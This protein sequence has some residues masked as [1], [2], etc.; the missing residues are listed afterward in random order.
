MYASY[1]KAM[2]DYEEKYQVDVEQFTM[3]KLAELDR[4]RTRYEALREKITREQL[5]CECE[6]TWNES[7]SSYDYFSCLRC[8]LKN[9]MGVLE[10]SVR[11]YE[12][13]LPDD[14]VARRCV[15]FH[16][17]L[18]EVLRHYRDICAFMVDVCLSEA[19]ANSW[20]QMNSEPHRWS[21]ETPF[22]FL[23]ALGSTT[24]SFVKTHYRNHS[25]LHPDGDF[26]VPHGKN[27]VMGIQV[28]SKKD[29]N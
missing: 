15:I 2:L 5:V 3:N 25:I 12:R 7:R 23:M 14:E 13:R 17:T 18:P 21:L 28:C 11:I 4:A 29:N 10:K 16:S 6:Q 26:V 20:D 19:T 27:V 22:S 9:E 8:R 24:K 1:S